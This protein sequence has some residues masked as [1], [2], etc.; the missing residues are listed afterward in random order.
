VLRNAYLFHIL[1]IC[2]ESQRNFPISN[3]PRLWNDIV[4]PNTDP[5]DD[6]EKERRREGGRREGCIKAEFK[7]RIE[8]IKIFILIF[9]KSN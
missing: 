9:I 4:I 8:N 3:F 6:I 7:K 1:L 2:L 5:N